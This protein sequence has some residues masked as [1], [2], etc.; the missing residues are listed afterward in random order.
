MPLHPG[1]PGHG[2]LPS[3]FLHMHVYAYNACNDYRLQWDLWIRFGY[4]GFGGSVGRMLL[5]SL[6]S[7]QEND[8]QAS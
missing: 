6:E 7:D 8:C 5:L 4:L 1:C 2:T 3:S